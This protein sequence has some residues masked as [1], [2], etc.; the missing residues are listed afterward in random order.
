MRHSLLAERFVHFW[1]VEGNRPGD[2]ATY[3]ISDFLWQ[4]FSAISLWILIRESAST[5]PGLISR[6]DFRLVGCCAVRACQRPCPSLPVD[7]CVPHAVRDL[8]P[9]QETA[10][11]GRGGMQL[12][13]YY[14]R[15]R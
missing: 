15:D 13:R 3:L 4:R 8:T 12:V 10:R 6:D 1:I 5:S 11:Y 2:F 14:C 9:R 7:L